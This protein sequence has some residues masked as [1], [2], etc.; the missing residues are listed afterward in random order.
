MVPAG[1]LRPR[2]V[3]ALLIKLEV[4]VGRLRPRHLAL[5]R[6]VVVL[7]GDIELEDS[8]VTPLTITPAPGA[9]VVTVPSTGACRRRVRDGL[10][11]LVVDEVPVEVLGDHA[12]RF[13]LHPGGH[14]CRPA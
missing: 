13:G 5:H 9:F 10:R 11:V 14:E 6:R 12:L 3:G 1:H 4:H 2:A 7:G 8:L